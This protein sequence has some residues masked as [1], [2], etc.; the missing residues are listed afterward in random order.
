MPVAPAASCGNLVVVERTRVTTSNPGNHPAFPPRNG[1]TAYVELLCRKICQNG[2]NGRS[3]IPKPPVAGSE[4]VRARSAA[5]A[6]RGAWG[7]VQV[8][9]QPN[10]CMGLEGTEKEGSW[11]DGTK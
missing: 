1:L 11:N 5:R 8:V 3:H 9:S 2:A 6:C 4:P 10:S 7:Q